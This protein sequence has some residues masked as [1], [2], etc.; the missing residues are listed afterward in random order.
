MML[1]NQECCWLNLCGSKPNMGPR[2]SEKSNKNIVISLLAAYSLLLNL[3]VLQGACTL[4]SFE[5]CVDSQ[6][7]GP[8][9]IV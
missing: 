1:E 5:V 9:L 8:N 2:I 6:H 4:F 7:V 3:S